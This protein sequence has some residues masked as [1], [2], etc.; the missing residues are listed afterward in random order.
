M[1]GDDADDEGALDDSNTV[2]AS[3]DVSVD[4]SAP[5]PVAARAPPP[6]AAPAASSPAAPATRRKKYSGKGSRPGSAYGMGAGLDYDD[7]EFLEPI[8]RGAFGVVYKYARPLRSGAAASRWLTGGARGRPGR[9]GAGCSGL[10]RG[11]RVAIK[12][13]M[14]PCD[15]EVELMASI[16]HRNIVTCLGYCASPP[17][18]CMIIELAK[19]N[20]KHVRPPPLAAE[21][22]QETRGNR[23]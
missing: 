14:I 2:G 5:T 7:L 19:H 1:G 10:W 20:L 22:R 13:L 16:R 11:M 15:A 8:G 9:H 6:A 21:L 4:A 12:K 23:R 3:T 17:D 18:Y